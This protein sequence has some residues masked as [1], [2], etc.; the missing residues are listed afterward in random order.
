MIE[1][2]TPTQEFLEGFLTD[3]E[4][5]EMM[6]RGESP[7]EAYLDMLSGFY[8][9]APIDV[10]RNARVGHLMPGDK[11]DLKMPGPPGNDY[12]GEAL[13]KLKTAL[14]MN[15]EET[16]RYADAIN[17]LADA[18]AANAPD[19]IEFAR[20]VAADGA[21]A[22]FA[23]EEVLTLGS[24]MIAMCAQSDVAATSLRNAQ[25]ALT[26][27]ESATK[28]QNAAFRKLGLSAEDV[29]K[30]MPNNAMGQF[31]DVLDRISKLDQ[32]EQIATMS[33]L[34]GDEARAL[35]PLLGQ[36]GQLRENVRATADKTNY[37]G[38]VQKEFEIRS[39]TGRYALQRF[40]NQVRDVGIVIG[41]SM[42]PAM[43]E[44]LA[45][46]G[47][48]L[49]KFSV[50]ADANGKLVAGV[51]AVTAGLVGLRVGLAGLRFIGLLGKGGRWLCYR[52]P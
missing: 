30:Q 19:L 35:M 6:T 21:V 20:R 38:S 24:S 22:G 14:G 8:D 51:I 43:K 25:K 44:I 32:H 36:L 37:L 29:A 26:K 33:N 23:R 27:G 39:K 5:A 17:F 31:L 10:G 16:A 46:I 48:I 4:R 3:R 47:P 15:I 2:P 12:A 1:G 13:A 7:V 28:R 52:A 11:F 40:S 42:L 50:W 18:N 45:T 9:A 41:K 49:D 34:F